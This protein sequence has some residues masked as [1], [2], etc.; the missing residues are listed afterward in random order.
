M[1]ALEKVVGQN[2]MLAYLTMMAIR[3]IELKRV[4]KNTGSIYL[5]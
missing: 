1:Q 3:L 5:H 2:D 4:L